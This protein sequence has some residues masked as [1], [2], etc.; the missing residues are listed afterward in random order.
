MRVVGIAV[1]LCSAL[2]GA[3]GAWTKIATPGSLPGG[4]VSDGNTIY[5]S[6]CYYPGFCDPAFDMIYLTA[7][8]NDVD[9]WTPMASPPI[10]VM[11]SG[12]ILGYDSG[13][14][15]LFSSNTGGGFWRVVTK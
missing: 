13:H 7:S 9:T 14:H 10:S 2:A 15:I 8:E 4:V 3:A 1:L 6:T 12:G 5:M 11:K